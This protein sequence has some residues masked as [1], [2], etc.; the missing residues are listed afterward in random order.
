MNLKALQSLIAIH[1]TQSFQ[2]AAR[3]LGYNQSAISMQ[4]K[5]LEQDLGVEL[6]DRSVRPPSMTA[7][8]RAL[9]NPAR[10]IVSLVQIIRVAAQ[11]HRALDGRLTL[12][13]I[14][15]V[16]ANSFPDALVA[17]RRLYPNIQIK[18]ESGLS[19]ILTERVRDGSIDAAI[20]TEVAPLPTTLQTDVLAYDRL[21]MI[22]G[23]PIDA[24]AF[25]KTL[26][27]QPFIRFSPDV[28][29]GVVV[30]KLLRKLDVTTE[31]FMELDSIES[32]VAMVERNIGV[33]IVPESGIG[34]GHRQRV[35]LTSINLDEAVR[36]I[37]LIFPDDSPKKP[38][39]SAISEALKL[40]LSTRP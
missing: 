17:L 35:F 1:E 27:E 3:R 22:S 36:K 12:G 24:N 28:G 10:E 7:A 16:V 38:L 18:V 34:T 15:T 5:A 20:V 6:F 37:S 25:I 31:S 32:I 39:V 29:V 26:S 21:V 4:I 9:I 23:V 2:E 33:S 40:A 8:S 13:V 30:E 19:S 14:P 11:N